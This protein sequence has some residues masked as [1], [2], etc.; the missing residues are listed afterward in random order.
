[1]G[2]E[3]QLIDYI[4]Q[5]RDKRFAIGQHDCLTFTNGAWRSMH[6]HGYADDVIGEYADLG[7]K[8]FNLFM[9]NK[10]GSPS[11]L[12]AISSRLSPA[13]KYPKKGSLVAMKTDRPYFS[14][15]ALGIS[16]GVTSVFIG[17][18]DVVYMPTD[19]VEG[20]WR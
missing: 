18:A 15:Y 20:A 4:K 19:Q 11:L 9:V 7:P 12:D 1:M 3:N 10:F 5:Q 17:E 16:L 13:G 2:Q 6:G 14:G 8:Q